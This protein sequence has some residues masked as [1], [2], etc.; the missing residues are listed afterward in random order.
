MRGSFLWWRI[1]RK[2]ASKPTKISPTWNSNELDFLNTTTD[3][4]EVEGWDYIRGHNSSILS[5]FF[6]AYMSPA[7]IIRDVR[8]PT[9]VVFWCELRCKVRLQVYYIYVIAM[10]NTFSVDI[11]AR[12]SS[13]GFRKCSNWFEYSSHL[14]QFLISEFTMQLTLVGANSKLQLCKSEKSMKS[15]WKMGVEIDEWYIL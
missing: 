15:R 11:N 13:Q 2:N 10:D 1:N 12:K 5:S 7:V 4:Q 8:V 9:Q 14:I 6:Y 3:R